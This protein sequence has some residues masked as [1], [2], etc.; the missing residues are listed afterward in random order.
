[1][2]FVLQRFSADG[3]SSLAHA[4]RT[5][6]AQNDDFEVRGTSV[7]RPATQPR[8]GRKVVLS[9]P[10][11]LEI[12]ESNNIFIKMCP[13]RKINHQLMDRRNFLI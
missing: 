11:H 2:M 3:G 6:I 7:V 13:S 4:L 8:S 1:M 9:N 10:P 5:C 12:A